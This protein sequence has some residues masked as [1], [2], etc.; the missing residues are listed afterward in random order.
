MNK[1][2]FVR[3]LIEIQKGVEAL[4][5]AVKDLYQAWSLTVDVQKSLIQELGERFDRS[6]EEVLKCLKSLEDLRAKAL[7][8]AVVRGDATAKDVLKTILKKS[9]EL[10]YVV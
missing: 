9:R 8:K 6:G 3:S 5:D 7:I 10:G 4:T 2:E 1:K